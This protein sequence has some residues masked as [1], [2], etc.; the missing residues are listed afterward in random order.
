MQHELQLDR[1]GGGLDPRLPFW[2]FDLCAQEPIHDGVSLCGKAI[3]MLS[4]L[5]ELCP[6]PASLLRFLAETEDANFV[7]GNLDLVELQGGRRSN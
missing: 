1:R 5:S 7:H 3:M 6:P 4:Q 2:T